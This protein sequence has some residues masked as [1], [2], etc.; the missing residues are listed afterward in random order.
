MERARLPQYAEFS[1]LCS[2]DPYFEWEVMLLS[3]IPELQPG[4]PGDQRSRIVP[5]RAAHFT[6]RAGVTLQE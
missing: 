1:F 4:N 3:P 6:P 5:I 2:A